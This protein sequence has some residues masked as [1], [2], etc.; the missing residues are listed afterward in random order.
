MEPAVGEGFAIKVNPGCEPFVARFNPVS[1]QL[2]RGGL[3]L[4]SARGETW[5]FEAD[6]PA[7][8]HRIPQTADPVLLVRK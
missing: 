4:S 7:N 6:D 5:L 8:W 1:W 3:T 2:E